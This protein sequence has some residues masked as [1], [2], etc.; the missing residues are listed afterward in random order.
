[1]EIIKNIDT[2]LFRSDIQQIRAVSVIAVVLFHTFPSTFKYGY[3]GVD[4]FFFLSG[5]LIFPQLYYA[6]KPASKKIIRVNIK[7]FLSRRIYRIAPGLGFCIVITWVF[8]FFFGPTPNSFHGADLFISL[9]TLFGVGNMAAL[10]YSSDYFNSDSPF[11]HFW[12]IGVELQA[13]LLFAVLTLFFAVAIRKN[14]WKFRVFLLSLILFSLLSKYFFRYHSNLFELVGLDTLAITGDYSNFYVTS[15]RIWQ[16]ALGGL[17]STFKIK[18]SKY[19][20]VNTILYIVSTFFIILMFLQTI[21]DINNLRTI[22][23]LIST[24][25]FLSAT[26]EKK[27]KYLSSLLVWIGDRSYS[28]YLYH[29]PIF[30]VMHGESM[31]DQFK[32]FLFVFSSILLVIISDFS[33]KHLE[34]IPRNK[35]IAPNLYK[36]LLLRHKKLF[37]ISYIM[38]IS[39]ILLVVALNNKFPVH[40]SFTINYKDN[41]AASTLSKC[42]LGQTNDPCVISG[43]EGS[44]KWLLLGDSHAGALQGVLAEISNDFQAT[45]TV[46]N[47]CRFFDPKISIDLNLFFPKWCVD[48]NIKRMA[49]IRE[50]DPDIIFISYQNT[51][52]NNGSSKM[53]QELWQNVFEKTLLS[54][55][56]NSNKIILFSQVPEYKNSPATKYRYGFSPTKNVNIDQIVNF[57]MNQNFENNLV[58]KGVSIIDI[59]SIFCDKTVCTRYIDNWLYWDSNHLSNYGANL[60]KPKIQNYLLKIIKTDKA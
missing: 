39:I 43:A 30:Y 19:K 37:T 4:V 36:Y 44:R 15:N 1:M 57:Q 38:P 17:F 32:T 22:I 11:T 55:T 29:L 25:V 21:I 60:V 14:L 58:S 13:Y 59:S 12:S 48:S 2:K 56:T 45:L 6:V 46:W 51:D 3:L 9:L 7:N 33:F 20:K 26:V 8:L 18:K 47:K 27:N 40:K 54:I 35:N 28:I 16:F 53:N 5:F 24:G 42:P 49:F 50:T 10:N 23:I 31:P 41:Y 34:K 52:V